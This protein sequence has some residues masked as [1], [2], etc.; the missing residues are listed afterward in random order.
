MRQFI[1][2]LALAQQRAGYEVLCACSPG[3]HWEELE[4]MG[5]TMIPL[6]IARSANP[7]SALCSILEVAYMLRDHTP[8]IFHVHTPIASMIGRIGAP[9]A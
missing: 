8:D 4:A 7:F 1:A 9:I 3:A 5:L 2:P 6:K